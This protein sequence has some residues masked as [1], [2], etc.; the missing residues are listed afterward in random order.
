MS[1]VLGPIA[2]LPYNARSHSL[3]DLFTHARGMCFGM[4]NISYIITAQALRGDRQKR[5]GPTNLPYSPLCV[6]KNSV[7]RV[8]RP[9]AHSWI[10]LTGGSPMWS[11]TFSVITGELRSPRKHNLSHPFFSS[12]ILR[13]IS[14]NA[15]EIRTPRHRYSILPANYLI[16]GLTTKHESLAWS[17]YSAIERLALF[18]YDLHPTFF[19]YGFINGFDESR[20]EVLRSPQSITSSGVREYKVI[21]NSSTQ[22][23]SGSQVLP[24]LARNSSC[25]KGKW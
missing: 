21:Q 10:T 13:R 8:I 11:H 1:S 16:F 24:C 17:R 14:G 15:G 25:Q 12:F 20:L 3:I 4:C 9:S 7:Y 18:A 23:T 2:E 19:C 22:C 6:R 5:F